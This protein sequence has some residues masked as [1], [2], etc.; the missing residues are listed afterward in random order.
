[1]IRPR[2]RRISAGMLLLAAALP[3]FGGS[4]NEN[5][6]PATSGSVWTYGGTSGKRPMS[7]TATISAVQKS[8]GKTVV[9]IQWMR[10]GRG[11]QEGYEVTASGVAQTNAGQ[12]GRDTFLPPLPIL[13]YPAKVGQSWTWK[14]QNVL[15]G[16]I[17]M[18]GTAT[19]R[20]AARE[21]VQTPAG[22]FS[23]YR[24]EAQITLKGSGQPPHVTS[25]TYWFA[26]KAGLVKH[27]TTLP[28]Q[29]GP[30]FVITGAVTKYTIK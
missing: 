18:E 8:A 4:P 24:V 30:A 20:V 15:G 21:K 1:M 26:P 29:S 5:L 28:V 6:F 3:A 10:N 25:R 27:S 11:W 19:V 16:Q 13:K 12:N 17:T 23:A 14:G 2:N 9:T 7:E 22:A